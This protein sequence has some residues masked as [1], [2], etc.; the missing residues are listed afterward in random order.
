MLKWLLTIVLAVVLIGIF[1][2]RLRKL[3]LQRMPGDIE[4]EREGRRHAFPIG[5][6]ILLSLLASLIYWMLR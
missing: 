4:I 2:P 3:G 6:T 1:T 5:S